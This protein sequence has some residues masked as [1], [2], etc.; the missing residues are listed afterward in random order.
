LF[1]DGT[2]ND[3][4]YELHEKKPNCIIPDTQ[5]FGSVGLRRTQI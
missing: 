3:T 2:E 5:E 4:N 1:E